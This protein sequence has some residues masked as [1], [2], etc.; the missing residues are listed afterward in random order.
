MNNLIMSYEVSEC[1]RSFSTKGNI[2]TP[3]IN[4]QRG[5]YNSSKRAPKCLFCRPKVTDHYSS[6]CPNDMNIT[7]RREKEK[8]F[9]C[10]FN[11]IL[12]G[13]LPN[14]H[15]AISCPTKNKKCHH[16]DGAHHS[17]LCLMAKDTNYEIL[18][19]T[20]D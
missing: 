3:C 18:Q 13:N 5:G 11:C 6:R 19:T 7:T 12:P 4:D 2:F 8:D 20:K 15:N 9:C 1:T 10:C 14:S 16:W 17:L